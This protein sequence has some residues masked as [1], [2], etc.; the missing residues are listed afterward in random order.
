MG[1]RSMRS[2]KA[3]LAGFLVTTGLIVTGGWAL[4]RLVA[5]AMR[6][7]YY[8]P[9]VGAGVIALVYTAAAIIVGA[10]VTARIHN[11]SQTMSGF[12]VAQVFFG[13]G[14]IREFWSTGASWYTV[15]ALVLVIPCAII[16]QAFARR[17]LRE[18]LRA[19]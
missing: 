9:T 4:G 1:G 12:I 19:A 2:I 11:S 8:M 7:E 16:G 6:G 14:L 13:F 15:A 5:P 18:R 17:A 3:V 10:Y